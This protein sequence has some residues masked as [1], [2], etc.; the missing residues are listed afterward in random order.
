MTWPDAHVAIPTLSEDGAFLFVNLLRL[1]AD[2]CAL[3]AI[4]LAPGAPTGEPIPLVEQGLAAFSYLG[5][6][7]GRYFF[8]TNLGAPD[9]RVVAFDLKERALPRMVEIVGQQ[10]RPLAR[11]TRSVRSERSIVIGDRLYL[12]TLDKTR[13]RVAEYDLA[14]RPLGELAIPPARSVGA[15]GGDRYGAVGKARGGGLIIALWSFTEPPRAFVWDPASREL[16]PAADRRPP[17]LEGVDIRQIEYRSFDGTRVPASIVALKSTPRDGSAPCLLYGYG[18]AGMAI[19]PEFAFDVLGWVA[20]GGV[21]V[22]AN[23]R[24]GGEMGEAW[25]APARNANKQVTFGDFQAA[26]EH[27]IAEGLARPASLGIRGISYGGLLVGACLTQRPDL[28]GAVV[29]EVPLLDPLSIGKTYWSAQLALEIGNPTKNAEAFA[30]IAS[31][32]P[33]QNLAAGV[34][35]PPTLVVIADADAPLLVEGDASSSPPC[36]AWMAKVGL[37]AGR[38]WSISS[39]APATAAG[40]RASSST[41]PAASWLSWRPTSPAG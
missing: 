17:R 6:A 26:A 16:T 19:T 12:T 18:G 10:D 1:V 21:W 30:A 15:N 37:G 3:L 38:T 32:S 40:R 8:E 41:P 20:L 28:F 39:A 14:G 7:G 27:L 34:A 25:H 29:A 36:R 22:L 24:G 9:G 2:V 11:S 35:Y 23:I 5:E 13:H 33:L 31:Y 4:P